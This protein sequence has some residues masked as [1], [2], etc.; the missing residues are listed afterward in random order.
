MDPLLQLISELYAGMNGLRRQLD[1]TGAERD[2]AL[3]Q[4]EAVTAERDQLL[5]AG[6]TTGA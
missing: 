2:E 6:D 1:A 3:R 4:L 5:R